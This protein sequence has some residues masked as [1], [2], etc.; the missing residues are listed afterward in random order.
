MS[1]FALPYGPSEK[2]GFFRRLERLTAAME[3]EIAAGR[4]PASRC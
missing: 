3:R 2:L 4:R 1:S